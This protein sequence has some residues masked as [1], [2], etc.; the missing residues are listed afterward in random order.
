[1]GG[2]EQ[3]RRLMTTKR[4]GPKIR[5]VYSC[6]GCAWVRFDDESRNCCAEPTMLADTLKYMRLRARMDGA[7]EGELPGVAPPQ[8]VGRSVAPLW[9]PYIETPE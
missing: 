5:A 6:D 2:S 4:H 9:C 1:M 3:G 7:P 8:V